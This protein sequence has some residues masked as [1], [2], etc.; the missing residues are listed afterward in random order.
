MAQLVAV[1]EVF[2]DPAKIV[3]FINAMLDKMID[4][5][6]WYNGSYKKD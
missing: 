2:G 5:K 6:R 4:N 1:E 3:F